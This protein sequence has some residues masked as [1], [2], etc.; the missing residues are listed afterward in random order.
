MSSVHDAA[1][2]DLAALLLQQAV[3]G[4]GWGYYPGKAARIEPT[5][6]ALLALAAAPGLPRPFAEIAAP[7]LRVLARTQ[8]AD[9]LLVDAPGMPPNFASNGLAACVLAGLAS[10][11]SS[12]LGPL[13]NALTIVKGVAVAS[14]PGAAQNNMLQAWPWLPDTFSWVEPTAWCML[15]LK[16]APSPLRPHATVARLQ[17]ADAMLRNRQCAGGGWNYGN[18]SVL[19]QDLRPYVPTSAMGIL[20][21]QDQHGTP[22]LARALAYLEAAKLS[23][24]SA[25]AL[26][27]AAVALHAC[28]RPVVD[29][30]ARLEEGLAHAR[31][32]ANFH[33]LSA[34]LYALGLDEHHGSA[35][36]V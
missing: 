36:R 21:L 5:A 3:P 4:G 15:A 9:G 28:D 25:M 16:K 33:H 6:W 22:D 30:T 17:E 23:E 27:M 31:A 13:L 14:E 8:R 11:Q 32:R 19:G 35:L 10:D 29:V 7:H 2:A 24:P 34:A 20:A 12:V 26:S 1:R 18:A